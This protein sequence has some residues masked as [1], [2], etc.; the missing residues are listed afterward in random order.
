MN[1]PPSGKPGA[2][3]RIGFE[4][5]RALGIEVNKENIVSL[6]PSTKYDE[7]HLDRYFVKTHSNTSRKQ[8]DLERISEELSLAL[9]VNI[10]E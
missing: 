3:Q 1:K 2:V 4:K 6:T 9:E 10:V 5:V 7:I 8:K